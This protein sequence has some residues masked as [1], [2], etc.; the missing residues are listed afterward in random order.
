MQVIIP[1]DDG[2]GK[3]EVFRQKRDE[4]GKP[5]LLRNRNPLLGFRVYTVLFEDYTIRE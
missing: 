3:V 5:G 1:I 4:Y 2:Y